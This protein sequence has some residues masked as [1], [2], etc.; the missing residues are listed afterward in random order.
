V[1]ITIPNPLDW[2]RGPAYQ[3]IIGQ[4]IPAPARVTLATIAPQEQHMSFLSHFGGILRKILHLGEEAAIMAEPIVDLGFPAIAPL[5][6]TSIALALA[7]EA[8]AATATGSGP[9]KLASL[10]AKM[11]PQAEDFAV[12]NGLVFDRTKAD[13][14]LSEI[15][16]SL[17]K[18]PFLPKPI[19]PVVVA[20][21]VI[22]GA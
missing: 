18:A 15:V 19:A 14:W 11:I 1:K 21:V 10:T 8:T 3:P 20:P 16:D 17:N 7:E 5:Y 12:K 9:Q 13:V 4:M 2:F 6:N 22:T